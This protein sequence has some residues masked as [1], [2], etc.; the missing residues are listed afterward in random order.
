V[1]DAVIRRSCCADE[2]EDA[3]DLLREI[4][5]VIATADRTSLQN[6]FFA[7]EFDYGIIL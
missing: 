5:E 3:G 6:G 1:N 2:S 7:E 4:R